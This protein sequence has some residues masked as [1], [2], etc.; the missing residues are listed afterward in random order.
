MDVG[1]DRGY[2]VLKKNHT[3]QFQLPKG[4]WSSVVSGCLRENQNNKKR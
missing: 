2:G 3:G 1:N 4:K